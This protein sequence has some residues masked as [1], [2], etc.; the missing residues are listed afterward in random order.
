[1]SEPSKE[2]DP[3]KKP[4]PRT[5]GAP[6]TRDDV[7]SNPLPDFPE[8]ESNAANDDP[9]EEI[10]FKEMMRDKVEKGKD[11]VEAARR[12]SGDILTVFGSKKTDEDKKDE[13]KDGGSNANTV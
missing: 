2:P 3:P 10:T 5:A 1:M 8:D 4:E 11:C 6:T 9:T 7:F 13:S 12:K